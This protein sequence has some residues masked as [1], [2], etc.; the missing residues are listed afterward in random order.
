MW[1]HARDDA[2]VEDDETITVTGRVTGLTVQGT[3]L[4]LE[5]DDGVST[6]VRLSAS[7]ASLAEGSGTT[8]VAVTAALNGV[9]RSETTV[10]RV[11]VGAVNDSARSGVDYETVADLT[12][13]IP[14]GSRARTRASG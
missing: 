13:T 9:V 8:M 4:T 1:I 6:S 7:P 2:V 10:V 14:A 11:S 5:D 3:T 12:L